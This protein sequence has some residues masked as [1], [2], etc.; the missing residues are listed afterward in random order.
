[1][2][3]SYVNQITEEKDGFFEKLKVLL[4]DTLGAMSPHK[5]KLLLSILLGG[6][7]GLLLIWLIKRLVLALCCSCVGALLVLVGVESL[8]MTVGLQMCN[9]LKEHRL[10]LTVTYFSMVG[11]GTV[12]QLILT[13][14]PKAKEANTEKQ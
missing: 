10:V 13:K 5:W 8:L 6:I 1:M 4:K 7:G 3:L 2:R 9:A 11:I 12:V 14:S